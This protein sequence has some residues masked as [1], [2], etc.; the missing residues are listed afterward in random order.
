[1]INSIL[2]NLRQ[3]YEETPLNEDTVLKDPIKQFAKWFEEAVRAG[4]PEP[5]AMTLATAS[6]DFKPFARIVLL[7]GI[8]EGTF[9][10]FTNYNSKKGK[11][12]LWKPY[13]TLLFFWNELHRQVRIEGR[14]KKISKKKSDEYFYSRPEESKLSAVISPQ[15]EV[16]ENR[17]WLEKK[18]AAATKDYSGRQIP[19]PE[20]WG[21]YQ[22]IPQAI[23]FWQ[24]RANRLHDRLQFTLVDQNEWKMKRLAP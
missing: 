15:S 5:N 7:K 21:G 18:L 11:E 16:I 2:K 24:G 20:H 10:F 4:L 13:A 3:E 6:V 22:V 19:R 14:V 12:L 8:E 9:L 23:E 17:H 1:M